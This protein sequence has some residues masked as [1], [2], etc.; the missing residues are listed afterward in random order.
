MNKSFEPPARRQASVLQNLKR[1]MDHLNQDR[2]PDSA[3]MIHFQVQRRWGMLSAEP[4]ANGHLTLC[5]P[6]CHSTQDISII[7]T[8]EAATGL[9]MSRIEQAWLDSKEGYLCLQ[10][11]DQCDNP[12]GFN[13][14][15]RAS[16]RATQQLL[17]PVML[18]LQAQLEDGHDGF[19]TGAVIRDSV[20]AAE[21]LTG[22]ANRTIAA[23]M[24][25]M[26]DDIAGSREHY[27]TAEQQE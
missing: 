24:Q 18:D 25:K 14:P 10:I 3:G 7:S 26:A 6:H 15:Q 9:C 8:L 4:D 17:A 12:V 5:D 22:Y 19:G 16:L 1:A 2:T 11:S 21:S 27:D 13:E 23:E 20:T